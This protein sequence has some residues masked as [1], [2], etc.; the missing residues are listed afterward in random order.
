MLATRCAGTEATM[1]EDFSD[2]D[3]QFDA[4]MPHEFLRRLE[5]HRS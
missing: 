1:N 4:R 2:H 5:Q 3:E